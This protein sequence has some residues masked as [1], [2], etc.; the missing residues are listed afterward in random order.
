MAHQRFDE[1]GAGAREIRES[2]HDDGV[3]RKRAVGIDGEL[4]GGGEQAVGRG[5]EPVRGELPPDPRGDARDR[6]RALHGAGADDGALERQALVDRVEVRLV[7]AGVEQVA[8]GA[9]DGGV[10]VD[11]R[12]E[13]GGQGALLRRQAPDEQRDER[14][15]RRRRRT[16]AVEDLVREPG[17]RGDPKAEPSRTSLGEAAEQMLAEAVRRDEDDDRGGGQLA[18]GKS[19]LDFGHDRRFG[20]PRPAGDDDAARRDHDSGQDTEVGSDGQLGEWLDGLAAPGGAVSAAEAIVADGERIVFRHAAGFRVGGDRLRAASGARFDAASLAKPWFATLALVLDAAERAAP[21]EGLSLSER[22]PA[23]AEADDTPPPAME[24]LL[25]HR[26]GLPAW[27]PLAA[28]LGRRLGDPA[29]LRAFLLEAARGAVAPTPAA[30]YSD[31]GYLLWGVLAEARRGAPLA[32]LLDRHICKPLA[33]T[34]LG[35]L[36]L[37]DDPEGAVECRLDN[38]REVELAAAQGVVLAPQRAH[39][40]GV[41]QDGNARA[42]RAVGRLGAHAGLFVT[43]D[44][45]LALGREWLRPTRLLSALQ[46]DEALAGDGAYALGWA[47]A[48]ESGS[49][50]PALSPRAFGHTGFTGGSLWIDPE[51]ERIYLLLAHRLASRIDFNPARREFHRLAGSL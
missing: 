25:R 44:E 34:S 38:G 45:M 30:V 41:P 31:L 50:G 47:R 14:V 32:T 8:H 3:R 20:G 16:G 21:G 26:A 2:V 48:S 40:R 29:A 22:L 46:I 9:D 15:P 11:E 49:S 39:R 36:A 4:L 6:Q 19:S 33:V 23:G 17:E 28:R 43:A 13:R 5:V 27:A 10:A 35:A 7:E 1:I 37:R 24:A 12:G 51:R 42:L 18:S